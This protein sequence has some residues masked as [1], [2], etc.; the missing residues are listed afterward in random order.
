MVKKSTRKNER[1]GQK[2]EMWLG[3][4][5]KKGWE[6]KRVLK[7]EDWESKMRENGEIKRDEREKKVSLKMCYVAR[8]GWP[9]CVV[10]IG[11]SFSTFGIKCFLFFFS[12][13]CGEDTCLNL[14]WE[15]PLF[16]LCIDL[17]YV[18]VGI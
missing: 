2:I 8:S 5:K 13:F 9:R 17:S 10:L 11:G 4:E 1:K 6:R 14:P 12:K 15:F 7:K 3:F 16:V 18:I